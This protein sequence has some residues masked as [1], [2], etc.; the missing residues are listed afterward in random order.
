LN[1][2]P[3]SRIDYQILVFHTFNIQGAA[4]KTIQGSDSIFFKQEQFLHFTFFFF[5]FFLYRGTIFFFFSFL[6]RKFRLLF[7]VDGFEG[8][9]FRVSGFGFRVSGFG[10]RVS[11][12]EFRISDFG[13]LSYSFFFFFFRG[14]NGGASEAIAVAVA[15][16]VFVAVVSADDIIGVGAFKGYFQQDNFKGVCDLI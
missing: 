3:N 4:T 14:E 1:R 13:F 9:G 15:V 12:F 2:L 16:A 8:F 6:D 7:Y 5:S 10:F 11:G